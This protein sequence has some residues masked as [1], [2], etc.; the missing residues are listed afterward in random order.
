[1]AEMDQNSWTDFWETVSDVLNQYERSLGTTDINLQEIVRIRME[2]F[3]L[4]LQ[5]IL[6]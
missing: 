1:M 5:Q 2:Y 6:P 4:A 3:I